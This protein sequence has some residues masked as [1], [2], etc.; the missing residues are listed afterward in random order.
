MLCAASMALVGHVTWLPGADSLFT[1]GERREQFRAES[2]GG[3]RAAVAAA[4]AARN[5]WYVVAVLLGASMPMLWGY[6][7]NEWANLQMP[8][9]LDGVVATV[10]SLAPAILFALGAFCVYRYALGG[11]RR[12]ALVACVWRGRGAGGACVVADAGFGDACVCCRCQR[13]RWWRVCL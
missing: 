13:S 1:P 2:G 7:R 9:T 11:R 3:R 12:P 4:F 5:R 6:F 10:S 8:T